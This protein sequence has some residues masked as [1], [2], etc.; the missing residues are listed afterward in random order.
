MWVF[1][2]YKNPQGIMTINNNVRGERN[3]ETGLMLFSLPSIFFIVHDL[4]CFWKS[5][6][7]NKQTIRER[8]SR[9]ETGN[10]W[11]QNTGDKVT[12]L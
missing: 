9:G 5:E 3:I 8:M 1:E 12:P 4:V 2:S 6:D 10:D 11:Q 7:L